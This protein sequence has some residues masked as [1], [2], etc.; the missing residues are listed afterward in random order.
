MKGNPHYEGSRSI[1]SAP[2]A[3]VT[4]VLR[5]P[6]PLVGGI[7]KSVIHPKMLSENRNPSPDQVWRQGFFRIMPYASGLP[8]CGGISNTLSTRPIMP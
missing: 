4:V 2:T 8:G 5:L 7:P 3:A 1:G 6:R